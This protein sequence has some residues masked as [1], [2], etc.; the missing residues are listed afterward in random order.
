MHEDA[1]RQLLPGRQQHGRP[2]DGVKPQHA[3]AEQVDAVPRPGP[4]APVGPAMGWATLAVA[5]RRHVVAQRVEPHVD[6]LVR[7]AGHRDAPAAGPAGWPRH[8]EVRQPAVDEPEHLV[9]APGGLD[10]QPAGGD[11]LPQRRGVPGQPEEPVLLADAFRLG[12]VLGA[13]VVAQLGR[14]VELLAAGAVQA[15]VLLPVQV[16][17]AG[18]PERLDAGPVPRIA[19]GAD[20]VVHAQ[21]QGAAERTER[22]GV[23]VDE[24]PHPEPGGVGREHVLQ[25]VVVGARLEPDRV[26]A[27][28]VV[29]GQH[30]GLDELERVPDVR[31]RVHV[32][33]SVRKL[34]PAANERAVGDQWA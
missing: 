21:R 27:P 18:P 31:A 1:G 32:G 6:D 25:R 2:V 4:P 33:V 23:A 14:T 29:A 10:P 15:G 17:G 5:Q 9:A 8:G 7:V 12:P 22:P 26:A 19:A 13:A 24:L 30:V 16:S 3:L 20:E 11:R 34:S 28:A